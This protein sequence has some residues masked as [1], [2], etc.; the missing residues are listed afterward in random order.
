MLHFLIDVWQSLVP[1]TMRERAARLPGVHVSLLTVGEAAAVF[2]GVPLPLPILELSWL[3]RR[4]GSPTH[5]DV[6]A[7]RA[8]R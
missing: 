2:A 7:V 8:V 6:P 1:E 5:C 3:R 4:G